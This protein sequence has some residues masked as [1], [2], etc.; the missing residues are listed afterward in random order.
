MGKT[1]TVIARLVSGLLISIGLAACSNNPRIALQ[2][3]A[4]II[5]SSSTVTDQPKAPV[6]SA[7][8]TPLPT[9]T[10]TGTATATPVTP[11]LS[12]LPPTPT[13]PALACSSQSG[14][15]ETGYLASEYS[16]R[17]LLFRIY[18]PP[19]YDE[20]P[21][22]RYPVL[23]L[24]H[25][26]SYTDDQW[27]RLGAPKAADGLI[28]SGEIPPFLIVMPRDRVWTQPSEDK[29]GQALL[30]EFLP[31]VDAHYR[32]QPDR[33]HRA[34]GG[35]SRGAAWAVHLGF[36]QW[37]L[38]GTIGAHSLPVFW[39]D[40]S[41]INRW[42]DQIPIESF[43]RIY[44]DIGDRD[45]PEVLESAIWFEELL[46]EKGIPHEWHLYSGEH[47]EVYWQS[48]VEQYLRWYAADW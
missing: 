19:C 5:T 39:E 23:Y 31:W 36:S 18:L 44:L 15:I 38:F 41:D 9:S 25:G 45:R 10:P 17:W 6:P 26:Q 20:Q 8:L 21:E 27:D 24:I 1:V 32:T 47:D 22:R 16:P 48:H 42:I 33:E 7:T 35:L 43:P 40:V 13:L 37:E 2:P 14:R 11:T 4:L 46:T 12:P 28:T 30:E 34:I 29:F 3:S